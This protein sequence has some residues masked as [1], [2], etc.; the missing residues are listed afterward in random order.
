[1][2]PEQHT[3]D[4]GDAARGSILFANALWSAI[5]GT[6]PFAGETREAVLESIAIGPAAPPPGSKGP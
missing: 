6:P 3:G 2:A 5:Y 1:M 4:A